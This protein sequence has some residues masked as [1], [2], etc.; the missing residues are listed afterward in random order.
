MLPPAAARCGAVRCVLLVL[1]LCVPA[2]VRPWVWT[3]ACPL[4]LPACACHAPRGACRQA[5]LLTSA[6]PGPLEPAAA[7]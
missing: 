3:V 5:G 6:G 1:A 2:C 7:Q 4:L